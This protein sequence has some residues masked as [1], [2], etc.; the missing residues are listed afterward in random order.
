MTDRTLLSID[1]DPQILDLIR[2]VALAMEYHVE[3]VTS[4]G[5]FMTTFVRTRPS[6][7]TVDICMPIVDGI[8]LLRWLGDVEAEA[9]VIIMSGAHP[10]YAEMAQK[11]AR[12]NGKM[13]VSILRK[14]FRVADL[15]RALAGAAL[16]DHPADPAPLAASPAQDPARSNEAGGRP[17][18]AL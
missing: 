11:L 12:A 13:E 15:R 17:P 18:A 16:D 3:A 2:K 14:P 7:V 10:P 5:A 1:D 9:R 4:A 6:V 8:E